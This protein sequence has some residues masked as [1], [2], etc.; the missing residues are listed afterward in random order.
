MGLSDRCKDFL[1]QAAKTG[2]KLASDHRWSC[3][4]YSVDDTF[5]KTYK[6]A[7]T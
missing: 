5:K 7:L 2:M 3:Y 6:R 4:Y 1:L